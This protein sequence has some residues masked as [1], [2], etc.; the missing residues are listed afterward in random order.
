MSDGMRYGQPLSQ[1]QEPGEGHL[2]GEA[3]PTSTR[4]ARAPF[5]WVMAAVVVAIPVALIAWL[6]IR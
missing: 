1:M 6:Y 2:Y 5:Y 3:R 4:N